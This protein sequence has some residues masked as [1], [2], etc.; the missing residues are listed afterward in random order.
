MG[1]HG[2]IASV[3]WIFMRIVVSP[4]RAHMPP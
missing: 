1:I 3:P 4:E 2:T